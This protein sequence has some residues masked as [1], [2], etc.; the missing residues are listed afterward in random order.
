M[1]GSLSNRL[2]VFKRTRVKSM[3]GVVGWWFLSL[4]VFRLFYF[5]YIFPA[6]FSILNIEFKKI[7]RVRRNHNRWPRHLRPIRSDSETSR[8]F[9]KKSGFLELD[10]LHERCLT[11]A[12]LKSWA[13]ITT[14]LVPMNQGNAMDQRVCR[15]WITLFESDRTKLPSSFANFAFTAHDKRK[16]FGY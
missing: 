1:I 9:D 14:G 13:Y 2:V 16:Y 7:R 10:R 12:V 3:K 15:T 4:F 6:H 8:D 11:E 5:T